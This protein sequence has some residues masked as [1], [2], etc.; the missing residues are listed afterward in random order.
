MTIMDIC[1][2][3]PA[4]VLSLVISTYAGFSGAATIT[5]KTDRNPVVLQESFQ[6]IFEADGKVDDDPDFSPLDKDFQV[7]ST[8][9]STNMSIVNAKIASTKQW[10]LTLLP[11]K[12]GKLIIPA[13]SFGKDNSPQSLLTVITNATGSATPDRQDIFIDVKLTPESAYVQAE[14]IYTIKLY[15][16][17]TTSNE[18]L[19]EPELSQGNAIIEQLDADRSY[20]T[21]LQG[22]R[23][24]VFERNYAIYPQVSGTLLFRPVRFQGQ[25]SAHSS[26]RFDLFGSRTKT[27]VR[28]S[29]PL[30]VEIKPIP[31]NYQAEH[32]LPATDVKITEKWS[33]DP[34]ALSSDEPVTRTVTI[35]AEGLTASQLPELPEQVPADFRQYPDKPVL[36]DR[37]S[38]G[39][40]TGIRQQ[41]SAIIPARAGEYTLPEIT[42][43]WWNTETQTI[44]YAVLPERRVQ[45]AATAP[46]TGIGLPDLPAPGIDT[47]EE[48][49]ALTVPVDTETGAEDVIVSPVSTIWQWLTFILAV[50]WVITLVYILKNRNGHRPGTK[51]VETGGLNEALKN[52]KRACRDNDPQRAKVALLQWAKVRRDG[53]PVSS[54]GDLEILSSGKLAGEI[55]NLSRRLYSRS[56]D[57]W[58]GEPLWQAFLLESKTTGAETTRT[59]GNLEPLFRL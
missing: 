17:I 29:E 19:S 16:S 4:F 55:R 5:V 14:M 37:Q 7:L 59:R 27:V 44:E 58:Q 30:R 38:A 46:E 24:T 39:G 41:K 51:Q 33:K 42:L 3:I 21:T 52:L 15:R 43:P 47:S 11:L 1:K 35:T 50:T 49:T 2:Y 53:A 28:Q 23:F 56:A 20:E 22:R 13:I 6:L 25:V 34:T 45:I 36:E 57:A 31:A 12:A 26:P 32:W 48:D 54:L 18:S 8:S 40:T 10:R 9:T